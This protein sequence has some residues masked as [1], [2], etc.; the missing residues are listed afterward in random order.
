M[1]GTIYSSLETPGG[2]GCALLE[3][4]VAIPAEVSSGEFISMKV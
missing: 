3:A 4:E 2:F 1:I